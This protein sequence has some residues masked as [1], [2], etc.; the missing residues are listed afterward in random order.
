MTYYIYR[1]GQQSGPFSLSDLQNMLAS[2]QLSP[3]DY[4]RTHD[5]QSWVPVSQIVNAAAAPPPVPPPGYAAPAAY[6][7]A[8]VPAAANFY[9]IPPNFHWGLV[10]LLSVVTCGIFTWVWLFVEASFVKRIDRGSNAILFYA[11]AL[12]C[13]VTGGAISGASHQ[14]GLEG[15]GTIVGFVLLLVGHYNIKSSLETHY[16][17]EEPINLRLSGVMV[18]F[19]AVFYYQYH[20]TRIAN[21]RRTG[22]LI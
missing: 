17:R 2:G 6:G 19:F 15:L 8:T 13:F 21:W 20:F 1:A 5:S 3:Q 18:F 11:I 7:A 16:N 22:V 9:P 12:A 4:A 10:L 14:Q